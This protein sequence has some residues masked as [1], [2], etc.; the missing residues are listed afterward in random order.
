MPMNNIAPLTRE[1]SLKERALQ[2]L[3]LRYLDE[4]DVKISYRRR[5]F[6][7]HP[8]RHPESIDNPE[9]LKS[10]EK[11][12]MAINQAYELLQDVL[13]KRSI[14]LAKYC[15]LEDTALVQLLLP[16]EVKPTPIGKTEQEL[17]IEKF[18]DRF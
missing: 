2:I 7:Y 1:E 13:G 8:D 5:I 12:I 9:Q 15:L 17:W 11:K 3:N 6:D 18:K 10:Y 14:D 16:E 4:A